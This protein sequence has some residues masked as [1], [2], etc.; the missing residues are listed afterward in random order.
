MNIPDDLYEDIVLAFNW[1]KDTK[2]PGEKFKSTYEIAA[3]LPKRD[4]KFIRSIPVLST[5]HIK[6]DT[7]P[8]LIADGWVV[9]PY[10]DGAFIYM[11]AVE[12]ISAAPEEARAIWDWYSA[13]YPNEWW[14]AFDAV[15]DEIDELPT[16]DW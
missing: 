1:V 8:S 15:G 16:Y 5:A 10:D 3:A 11:G 9:A 14:I 6:E 7:I 13:N 2:I 4:D 12:D